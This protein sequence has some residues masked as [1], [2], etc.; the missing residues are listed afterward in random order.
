MTTPGLD[1]IDADYRRATGAFIA[2]SKTG[3]VLESHDVT[4][5]NTGAPGG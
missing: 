3:E 1:G 5:T 4:I 2:T